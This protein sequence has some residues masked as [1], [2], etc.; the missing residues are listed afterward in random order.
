[1]AIAQCFAGGP[2]DPPKPGERAW[3]ELAK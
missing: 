2:I 3:E 1:M